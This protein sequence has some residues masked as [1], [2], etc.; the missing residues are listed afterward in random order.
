MSKPRYHWWAYAKAMVRVY[1]ELKREYDML[2]TPQ[3]TRAISG[4]PEGKGGVVRTAEMTALR[5]LP[6]ARQREYDAVTRAVELT[7][8]RQ[9]GEER[10]KLINMVFW[11]GTHNLTGAALALFISETTAKRYSQD[12]LTLVGYCYGLEDQDAS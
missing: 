9:N 2:H 11:K 4:A 6:P 7:K 12:F 3:I 5:Q 1:P 10:I 8:R